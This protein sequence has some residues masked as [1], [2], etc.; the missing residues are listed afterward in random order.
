MLHSLGHGHRKDAKDAKK[1]KWIIKGAI[2]SSGRYSLLTLPK[3]LI[4]V[5]FALFASLR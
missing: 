3:L 2:T 1:N 5:C 4:L